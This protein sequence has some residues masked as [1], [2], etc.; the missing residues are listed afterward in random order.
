MLVEIYLSFR[1]ISDENKVNKQQ[2]GNSSIIT[3]GT[4]R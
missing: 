2:Q 4:M 1:S 3:T